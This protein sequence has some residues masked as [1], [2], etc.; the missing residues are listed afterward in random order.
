[1]A[2]NNNSQNLPKGWERA[3]ISQ[4]ERFSHETGSAENVVSI[5]REGIKN[6]GGGSLGRGLY[7]NEYNDC[8]ME[9]DDGYMIVFKPSNNLN[10]YA[11]GVFDYAAGNGWE[12]DKTRVQQKYKQYMDSADFFMF[13]NGKS[14]EY[15]FHSSVKIKVEYIM[16]IK[17]GE[18][19]SKDEFL[20]KFGPSLW[21]RLHIKYIILLLLIAV[22]SIGILS[23]KKSNT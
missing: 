23:S 19:Y 14:C 3:T 10:G 13:N 16:D 15:V 8:A 7:A 18:K 6:I 4:N 21:S 1:M 5:L 17:S 9:L 20:S 12:P 2:S 11:V 22:V